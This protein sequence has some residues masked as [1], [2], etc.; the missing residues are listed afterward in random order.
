MVLYGF[1]VVWL[2][3]HVGCEHGWRRKTCLARTV[4]NVI[5]RVTEGTVL[6]NR[7]LVS[8]LAL[9]PGRKSRAIGSII[10]VVLGVFAPGPYEE[11]EI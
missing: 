10:P 5:S 2:W 9:A 3:A 8:Q 6:A 1:H 4:D 7:L 11:P